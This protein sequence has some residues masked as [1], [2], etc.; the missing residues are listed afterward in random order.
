M[1][2][3]GPSLKYD[4]FLYK[5]NFTFPIFQAESVCVSVL[6]LGTGND[7]GMFSKKMSLSTIFIYGLGIHSTGAQTSKIVQQLHQKS[8]GMSTVNLGFHSRTAHF[9]IAQKQSNF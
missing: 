8:M 2:M 6:P 4:N 7:L 1:F 5:K 3:D 9:H